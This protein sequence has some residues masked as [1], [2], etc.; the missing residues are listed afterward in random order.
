[1]RRNYT[2][3]RHPEFVALLEQQSREVD[4][5]KRRHLLRRM[6]DFLLTVED[7]YIPN[8]WLLWFSLV[9][10]K[11]CTE[12]GALQPPETVQT[13]LKQEYGGWRSSRRAVPAVPC[14][15]TYACAQILRDREEVTMQQFMCRR[16]LVGYS[17]S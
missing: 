3:W 8:R 1:M 6:E 5:D 16:W 17:V 13:V 4:R 7:P 14:P 2:C 11:V 10:D 12:A 15:W 9:S